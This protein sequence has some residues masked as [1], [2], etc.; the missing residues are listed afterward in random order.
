MN[1][2]ALDQAA[3]GDDLRET[4]DARFAGA[5]P[6]LLAI[7]WSVIGEQ[8]AEDVVQETYLRAKD[9]LDQLRDPAL[10]DAWLA[11][12][13]L[14][15]ARTFW[16]RRTRWPGPLTE[17]G[18]VRERAP[19]SDTALVELVDRLPVRERMSVVLH[20]GHGYSLRE[21][22]RLL[23]ISEINARTIVFRARRR[24]KRALQE[25]AR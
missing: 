18:L 23:G 13:A 6:V 8:E 9:R 14:N 1:I 20:Y 2:S 22:A 10:F 17:V 4:F 15:E 7:C 12:I 24:L 19:R 25:A 3:D 5:R 16:R 11:R 21:V